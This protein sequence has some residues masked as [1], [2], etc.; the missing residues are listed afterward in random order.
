[1]PE[2]TERSPRLG[3]G[4]VMLQRVALMALLAGVLGS[5]GFLVRA[6][7]RQATP[8]LLLLLMAGWV[9]APYLGLGW[10]FAA[11]KRWTRSTQTVLCTLMLVLPLVALPIYATESLRPA[12]ASPAALFVAVPGATW[13][14]GIAVLAIAGLAA[15]KR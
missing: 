13:V 15:R 2:P 12:K 6:G 5:L 1:M 8:G 4:S 3:E 9:I 11:S 14:F 7:Q 10:A